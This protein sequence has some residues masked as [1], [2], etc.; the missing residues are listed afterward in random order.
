MRIPTSVPF[1]G[2][3]KSEILLLS[4]YANRARELA[5]REEHMA[6]RKIHLYDR[7][8]EGREREW[9]NKD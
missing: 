7:N 2:Y 6:S 1:G 9:I 8:G 4:D 3:A 5:A